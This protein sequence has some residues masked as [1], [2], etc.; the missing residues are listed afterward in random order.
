MKESARAKRLKRH[1]RRTQ[2]QG[3]LNLVALMDIF[4]ILVFF[5]MVNSS[6]DVR[7]LDRDSGI[8]LPESSAEQTPDDV[9]ALLVTT[10]DIRLNGETVL[11]LDALEAHEGAV[12][13]LLRARLGEIAGRRERAADDDR[14]LPVTILAD[15]Q[16]PYALLKKLMAT[17][18]DAGF[19]RISLAVTRVTPEAG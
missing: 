14:G 8:V 19:G 7:L 18:V 9:P 5:L 15:Q 1:H 11:T 16:L 17:C 10:R 3:K 4:T 13:P 6:T 12:E 2:H